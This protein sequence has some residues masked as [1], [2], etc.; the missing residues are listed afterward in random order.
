MAPSTR[1]NSWADFE[2]EISRRI[3]RTFATSPTFLFRGDKTRRNRVLPAIARHS[4]GFD[5][6]ENRLRG[7]QRQAHLFVDQSWLPKRKEWFEWWALMQHYGVP[8]RLLDWSIS[9]YVAAY[10]ACCDCSAVAERDNSSQK[11]TDGVITIAYALRVLRREGPKL[12]SKDTYEPDAPQE[13]R[14]GESRI[15]SQRSSLQRGWFS[16]WTGTRSDQCHRDG[17]KQI[18]WGEGKDP[19]SEREIPTVDEIEIASDSKLEFLRQ[20]SF[21]GIT[22]QALFPGLVGLGKRLR[23]EWMITCHEH[24]TIHEP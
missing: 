1:V 24:A 9:P 11:P 15:T 14:F 7:F 19:E 3:D 10:F 22:A 17:L 23:E 21:R 2:K 16:V 20:L 13:I 6:E 8:T 4:N 18:T 12:N 5:S